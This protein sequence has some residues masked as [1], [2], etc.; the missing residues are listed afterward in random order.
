MASAKQ[1]G[2]LALL[3]TAAVAI[4][5][6]SSAATAETPLM[7]C[8]DTMAE[9]EAFHGAVA[10]AR[11]GEPP[12]LGVYNQDTVP[13]DRLTTHTRFNI[14]SMGKMFTA[15]A[16]GQL[17]D[18]GLVDFGDSV[19]QHLPDLPAIYDR[20]TLHHLLTHTGGTGNYFSPENSDVLSTATSAS[21]LLPIATVDTL[22]FEPGSQW[23]YSNSGFALLGVLIERITGERYADYI[24]AN[25]FA[26]AGM[27]S[28]GP[29][30]DANTASAYTRFS[31][32]TPPG[33][34]PS[35]DT[36]FTRSNNSD[37]RGMPAGGS[38][39]TVADLI[40]FAEALMAHKL[41]SPETMAIMTAAKPGAE[42]R[43]QSGRLLQF[44]YGF[45]V[46]AD[47]ARIGHGGSGAGVSA[48]LRIWTESNWVIAALAN[49]DPPMV[50]QFAR[51]LEATLHDTSDEGVCKL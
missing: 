48:Q 34:L 30:A 47:G 14:G 51:T 18:R 8:I 38:R 20:V 12:E 7:Q 44:G 42:V 19:R 35:P 15:V 5:A 50:T 25:V 23:S 40:L 2:G 9:R 1:T 31:P 41:M 49:V 32:G 43:T 26:P 46:G 29:E 21:D 22:Q 17:K 28:T 33:R 24:K 6:T 37:V 39:S 27:T 16:I 45:M 11:L 36:P 3:L 4:Q 10:V 13:G